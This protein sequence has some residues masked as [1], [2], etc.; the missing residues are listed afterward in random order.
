MRRRIKAL[1]PAPTAVF[2][3]SAGGLIAL[4]LIIR[5]PQLVRCCVL[6][7]PSIF[8]VLPE[9][10]VEIAARRKIITEGLRSGVPREAIKGRRPPKAPL[11]ERWSNVSKQFYSQN[12]YF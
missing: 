3:A 2:G 7:E 4:D 6:Q 9:P 12:E 5:Y 1:E 10:T 8:F 11:S